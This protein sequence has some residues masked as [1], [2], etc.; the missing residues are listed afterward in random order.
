MVMYR[1]LGC[2]L[3]ASCVAIA[4][5]A[6]TPAATA[7]AAN[8]SPDAKAIFDATL[9]KVTPTSDLRSQLTS[10]TRSL[11]IAG[12]IS[13]GNARQSATEAAQCLQQARN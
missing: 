4:A 3:F 10:S 12:T 6:D 2:V 8:L 13:R 9:P 7:C 5:R 1:L 11:A